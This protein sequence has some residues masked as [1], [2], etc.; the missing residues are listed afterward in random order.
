MPIYNARLTTIDAAETR[1]YAGLSKAENFSEQNILEACEEAGLL[2]EVRGVWKMYDYDSARK[3]LNSEPPF[4]I[5]GRSIEKHLETCEKVVC[6]AVTVGETIEREVT[7]K[8]KH[9][10]YVPA[11]LLDAA[12][13]SAV[14]QAADQMEQAIKQVVEREGFKMRSRYSPGYGDWSLSAQ[15]ELFR[16]S[17]ASEIGMRLSAA[18]MLMPRK[19][20]T[21]IIGLTKNAAQSDIKMHDCSACDKL[22]CPLR[23]D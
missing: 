12:A 6:M 8:F 7:S 4:L 20:I 3:E 14:E 1:R 15:K 11:M 22:D 18:L 23:N 17:G 5:V 21:A 2:I 13:T 9:G 16:V 10:N 19:S